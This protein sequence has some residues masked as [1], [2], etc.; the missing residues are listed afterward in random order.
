M[1]E[2]IRVL[3]VSDSSVATHS[4][5]GKVSYE[6]L[7]RLTK[8]P[9]Y[10]LA[11]LGGGNIEGKEYWTEPS[12]AVFRSG[13]S[14][15]CEDRFVPVV[16]EFKPQVVIS[17]YDAPM[18]A[19]INDYTK[20]P[21][22]LRKTFKGIAH[23][24]IDGGPIPES[25]LRILAGWN[26]IACIHW[27]GAQ[28]LHL[29]T[30]K[31]LLRLEEEHKRAIL[32]DIRNMVELQYGMYLRMLDNIHVIPHGVDKATY[33]RPSP[34][35][36]KEL[37]NKFGIS[38]EEFVFCFVGRNSIRKMIPV[39]L[40]AFREVKSMLPNT[41]LILGTK[42]RDVGGD[43]TEVLNYLD[44]SGEGV[45]ITDTGV[46]AG[47]GISD[48]QIA[49]LYRVSDCFVS[50]AYGGGFELC[51]LESM[52]CGLPQIGVAGAGSIDAMVQDGRG[53]AVPA[54]KWYLGG[55]LGPHARPLVTPSALASAMLTMAT[56]SDRDTM[57][58]AAHAY[59]QLECFDWDT[60]A[61]RFEELI[62]T[63]MQDDSEVVEGGDL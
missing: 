33:R 20:V 55:V 62:D 23:L 61:S 6:I 34:E 39:L 22:E 1:E 24:P 18:S 8:N 45:M 35:E 9:K 26:A 58:T 36:K 21:L 25:W 47:E 53:I 11:E 42:M 4:G 16:E 29:A 40:E 52:S 27:F 5:F 7:S 14:S 32:P 54:D 15:V 57:A 63:V 51:H 60:S 31:A 43:L 59:S 38:N 13:L 50:P 30:E 41:R 3:W 19:Y 44:M 46:A 2:K 17:L 37:R 10:E 49:N 56:S 28:E 48:A 12:W